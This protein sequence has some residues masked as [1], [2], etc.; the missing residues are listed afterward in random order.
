[1]ANPE[2]T[3]A[4]ISFETER[5]PHSTE[6]RRLLRSLETTYY[7]LLFANT[8][9]YQGRTDVWQSWVQ[10]GFRTGLQDGPPGAE[11]PDRIRFD[12]FSDRKTLTFTARGGREDNVDLW[13]TVL[14]DVDE[15]RSTVAGLEAEDRAEKLVASDVVD[16]KLVEPLRKALVGLDADD[17]ASLEGALRTALSSLTY[18][19]VQRCVAAK[20][21]P[22]VSVQEPQVS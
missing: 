3:T 1:M 18:P 9:T 16:H 11:V 14:Q 2:T 12:T 10:M 21:G 5:M 13:L 22:D 17:A 20:S 8:D 6:L 7:L 15:A 19:T 4:R